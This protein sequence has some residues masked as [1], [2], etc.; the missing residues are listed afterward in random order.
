[1]KK[2]NA[3]NPLQGNILAGLL[4]FG[5]PI[6]AFAM[7]QVLFSAMDIFVLSRFA[8][9]SAVSAIGVS[10]S[11]INT[12]VDAVTGLGGGITVAFGTAYGRQDR[13]AE[14]VREVFRRFYLNEPGGLCGNDDCGQMSAWYI[15][16]ALGKYP[17]NPVSGEFVPA[18]QQVKNYRIRNSRGEKISF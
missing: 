7:L 3:V 2:S 8:R 15:F 18:E 16:S 12:A 17:V 1:M 11:L 14:K 6:A 9:P 10:S 5:L 4:R 13:A